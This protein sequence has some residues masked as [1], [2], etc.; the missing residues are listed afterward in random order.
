MPAKNKLIRGQDKLIDEE[1]CVEV[2]RD[3]KQIL[4]EAEVKYWLD[5]GTLLGAVRD[6]KFIPWDNPPGDLGIMCA[7]LSKVIA[8]IPEMEEKGLVVDITDYALYIGKG[9]VLIHINLYHLKGAKA[10]MLWT[11]RKPK[12]HRVTRYFDRFGLG[13]RI[14][15]R[16]FPGRTKMP[17]LRQKIGFALIP[18]FVEHIIRKF[19]FRVYQW[20]G[21]K[22][23]A[24][25]IP[26][27]YYEN[28]DTISFYGMTF[29]IPSHVHD[30]LSLY[31][32]ENWM[33]P[34]P[35]WTYSQYPA[36]DYNFDIGK[37]EDLSISECLK[38]AEK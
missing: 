30:Y 8:K 23:C 20:L 11:A 1:K 34:D 31:Y 35:N 33:N 25:V 5:F 32:G 36:A 12:F 27:S 6:A 29:N 38:E 14:L 19:S 3:V 18:S 24:V 28:L 16:N 26:K 7:E 21:G 9:S 2:L 17:Y 37:R 4:D 22:Y 13:G 10:W 15:Y